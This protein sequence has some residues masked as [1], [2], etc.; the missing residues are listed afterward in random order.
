MQLWI[1][2]LILALQP[3]IELGEQVLTEAL[4]KVFSYSLFKN[5]RN[6]RRI[7]GIRKHVLKKYEQKQLD[8]LGV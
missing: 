3:D 4:S 8:W 1:H 7:F 2:L 5:L 6:F